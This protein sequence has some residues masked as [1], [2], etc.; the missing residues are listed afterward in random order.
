VRGY[1]WLGTL[2]HEFS[3]FVV[4]TRGRDAVRI[5]RQEGLGKCLGTRWRGAPGL[6]VDE[7]STALLTKAAR[8]RH[9][10][11]FSAMHPSIAKLPTQELAALAFAEVEAA[12]RLLHQRGG[13]QALTEL[14][15]AMAS[16]FSDEQA[17]AQAYGKSFSQFEQDWRADLLK[18]RRE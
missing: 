12:I 2:A 17:V 3:R 8:E 14:V 15:A 6:A 5:W 7:T 4:S 10:I 18:P 1:A 9:L 11:P 13:Q 16:G